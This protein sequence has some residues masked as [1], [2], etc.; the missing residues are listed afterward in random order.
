V[1]RLPGDEPFVQEKIP[2]WWSPIKDEETGRWISSHT[3]NQDIIAWV[4]QGTQSDRENEHLGESDRGVIMLR[5]RLLR[6]LKVVEDGGDPKAILRDP[7]RN[8]A[9]SLKP[10]GHG[11]TYPEVDPAYA[12][13]RDPE[14]MKGQVESRKRQLA[15]LF[16]G[17]GGRRRDTGNALFYG[18]PE[19]VGAEFSR[20]Y[21]ERLASL[22]EES[23]K[24]SPLIPGL[25]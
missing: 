20:I 5:Q 24:R 13:G 15:D 6:D 18:Q 23:P 2:Y 10:S 22:P 19:E 11:F 16:S 7:S 14:V 4:G 9:L 12:P 25:D 3:V 21:E 8:H 17:R 1:D